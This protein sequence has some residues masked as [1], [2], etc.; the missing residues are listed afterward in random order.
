MANVRDLKTRI[1]SV[2]NICQITRAMEMV[3]TTKLRRFQMRAESSGPYAQE[4]E[5][6]VDSLAAHV[7]GGGG[8]PL[9]TRRE[10][11]KTGI[12]VVTSDRGL[13]GAYNT[14]VLLGLR[15]YEEANPDREFLRYVIGKKGISYLGRRRIEVAGYFEDPPLEDMGYRDA[16]NLARIFKKEFLEERLD[17]VLVLYTAF[18]S[19]T[20]YE[21]TIFPFLP[22]GSV[23]QEVGAVT[24]PVDLLLEPSPARIFDQLI[25]KYL[26]TRMFNA[27]I[28]SLTSEYASRRVS[29]KNATDAATEM[30]GDLKRVYNRARQERITK[31]LLEIVGGAE[32]LSG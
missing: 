4:I 24:T 29:M 15:D 6:L 25:P 11:K 7:G 8:H 28:E 21:P 22:L 14:N 17:E 32:A 12:L 9:F 5:K 10:G 27:L 2:G 18:R 23:E 31:E 3:A 26:E 19:M 20:R 13:C 16:A 30:V 1:K